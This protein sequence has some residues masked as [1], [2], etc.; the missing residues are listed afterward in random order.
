MFNWLPF[1]VYLIAANIQVVLS[2]N[3][4]QQYQ[5]GDN[6][7]EFG[8]TTSPSGRVQQVDNFLW[9]SFVHT[10]FQFGL[11]LI[12]MC[13]QQDDLLMAGRNPNRFRKS[14]QANPD[15][16]EPNWT[17]HVWSSVSRGM[18]ENEI[19][20][21]RPADKIVTTAH[22]LLCR[23]VCSWKSFCSPQWTHLRMNE[24]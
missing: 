22:V 20:I 23:T 19:C 9:T 7:N 13:G 12:K 16:T 10:Y 8:I 3:A 17:R 14:S 2:G 1:E 18:N 21:Y 15:W 24:S 4:F 11:I 6:R 5:Q